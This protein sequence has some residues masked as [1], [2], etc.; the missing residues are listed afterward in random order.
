VLGIDIL[1]TDVANPLTWLEAGEGGIASFLWPK[2]PHEH[3]VNK[4]PTV[5]TY[6]HIYSEATFKVFL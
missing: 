3:I 5:T 2:K 6:V 4:I 1:D